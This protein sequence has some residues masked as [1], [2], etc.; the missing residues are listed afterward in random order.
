MT[1]GYPSTMGQISSHYVP[2][3]D[4]IRPQ[5]VGVRPFVYTP[6]GLHSMQHS[7][8]IN[9]HFN[10]TQQSPARNQQPHQQMMQ[11]QQQQTTKE[12]QPQAPS[13]PNQLLQQQLPN[14][15]QP[16]L[17]EIQQQI[18]VEKQHQHQNLASVQP[19]QHHQPVKVAPQPT[20]PQISFQHP[21]LNENL[22]KQPH[23][24]G[25]SSQQ[26]QEQV[27]QN[28]AT[29][30][31]VDHK[32]E[33]S[34]K[35]LEELTIT[36]QEEQRQN[37]KQLQHLQEKPQPEQ[38][39]KQ[40]QQQQQQKQQQLQQQRPRQQPQ[41]QQPQQQQLLQ[42]PPQQEHQQ[43][44]QHETEIN[45]Q[46]KAIQISREKDQSEAELQKQ[47]SE[48]KGQQ[49]K[50]K[51]AKQYNPETCNRTAKS[52]NELN[53]N[54]SESDKKN[55]K[56]SSCVTSTSE[57][58]VMVSS[59]IKSRVVPSISNNLTVIDE[60]QPIDGEKRHVKKE[61]N[62][63]VKEYE[64]QKIQHVLK[65]DQDQ[66][67]V[68]TTEEI[69]ESK[70][71]KKDMSAVRILQNTKME[72][73]KQVI[74]PKQDG[75]IDTTTLKKSTDTKQT[76]KKDHS[77]L[78]QETLLS[79]QSL[80]I[81]KEHQKDLRKKK[82]EKKLLLPPREKLVLLQQQIKRQAEALE[83][84][85]RGKTK[86]ELR[87]ERNNMQ[88]KASCVSV[89]SLLQDSKILEKSSSA[90]AGHSVVSSGAQLSKKCEGI[91]VL[92][93]SK[94]GQDPLTF[95]EKGEDIAPR[96]SPSKVRLAERM[97]IYDDSETKE[98]RPRLDTDTENSPSS[99]VP[100]KILS[101]VADKN[102]LKLI[103]NNKKYELNSNPGNLVDV[104]S[105]TPIIKTTPEVGQS[106]KSPKKTDEIFSS[107]D[108]ASSKLC[109]LMNQMS[110]KDEIAVTKTMIGEQK[111]ITV[112]A[113][114]TPTMSKVTAK[115]V[116]ENTNNKCMKSD[117]DDTEVVIGKGTPQSN[118]TDE[119][120]T[121]EQQ[122]FK[123]QDINCQLSEK[124]NMNVIVEE[125]RNERP[126]PKPDIAIVHEKQKLPKLLGQEKQKSSPV[127][128]VDSK[129]VNVLS[130]VKMSER[131]F[132][133]ELGPTFNPT[134]IIRPIPKLPLQSIS[135]HGGASEFSTMPIPTQFSHPHPQINN[136]Q[137][138][139]T[140]TNNQFQPIMR[141]EAGMG[142]KVNFVFNHPVLPP[143]PS[144]HILAQNETFTTNTHYD[145]VMVPNPLFVGVP[146]MTGHASHHIARPIPHIPPQPWQTMALPPMM[147][148]RMT[149]FPAAYP[150]V[151][152]NIGVNR[153]APEFYSKIPERQLPKIQPDPAFHLPYNNLANMQMRFAAG[154]NLHD[155]TSFHVPTFKVDANPTAQFKND[156]STD[157]PAINIHN[158]DGLACT[159]ANVNNICKNEAIPTIHNSI[160]TQASGDK[161][162]LSS[163]V[164]ND[165][166]YE[167]LVREQGN[168]LNKNENNM[169]ELQPNKKE[170]KCFSAKQPM[171]KPIGVFKQSVK[172]PTFN[173]TVR[174]LIS[175]PFTSDESRL[176]YLLKKRH[177]GH[178]IAQEWL[179]ICN[180][181][182][183]SHFRKL[184][185]PPCKEKELYSSTE[186]VIYNYFMVSVFG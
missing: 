49:Q 54:C 160:P 72:D 125:K 25:P 158:R 77:Q 150:P 1:P 116:S 40:E 168:S 169:G 131:N 157:R 114:A 102:S 177:Q 50:D 59:Q 132:K 149:H 34:Q 141:A 18:L 31:H 109:S 164:L 11:Y 21:Q 43:K 24:M 30:D 115:K 146:G 56:Q 175:V 130:N 180:G 148:P 135:S 161:S 178:P 17:T 166:T 51:K 153:N 122:H 144:P 147:H 62:S 90:T 120:K 165:L 94:K 70:Q 184:W 105:V 20:T 53:L 36:Y 32:E 61:D 74:S 39:Q 22:L 78:K 107:S 97:D 46:M 5:L 159:A 183:T 163:K 129:A 127:V 91:K 113:I 87:Q 170:T 95:T 154:R 69:K 99:K 123:Y 4:V 3:S 8:H 23:E 182:L 181:L 38:E 64:P 101:G 47:K 73:S 35:Q 81:E 79:K 27:K 7:H 104:V 45:Q 12:Y 110:L 66:P 2:M 10:Y 103:G 108:E 71:S 142:R 41:Q 60:K 124:Q 88:K 118:E 133:I 86:A 117:G 96:R 89:K 140:F 19:V 52:L 92:L 48:I 67:N 186:E 172:V 37:Q 9:Q 143:M 126:C 57:Q 33:S 119:L 162:G 112:T 16:S 65:A 106:L 44:M 13:P 139:Q 58:T 176:L 171:L 100:L 111:E 83:R 179:F 76:K 145:P 82:T 152:P 84:L 42:Q 173:R 80:Q 14:Q 29:L 136:M 155:E 28:C 137:Q 138:F 174:E 68:K 6:T 167:Q 156:F 63:E 121:P 55:L 98:K 93:P 85:T 26:Q 75:A 128:V 185:D 15:S 151:L 134:G